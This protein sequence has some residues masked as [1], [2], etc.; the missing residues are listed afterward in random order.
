[1]E[2]LGEGY[3]YFVDEVIET[4]EWGV[5]TDEKIFDNKLVNYVKSKGVSVGNDYTSFE[6]D[7]DLGRI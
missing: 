6:E 7:L 1:M 3:S 4:L 5:L 2:E